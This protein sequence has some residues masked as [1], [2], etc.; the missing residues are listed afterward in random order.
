MEAVNPV[1]TLKAIFPAFERSWDQSLFNAPG[2][3]AAA[4][5]VLAEFSHFYR[6][7]YQSF[8]SS[9]LQQLSGALN[10][11]LGGPDDELDNAVATCFLENVAGEPCVEPLQ[12]LLKSS[13]R[14]FLRSWKH[15]T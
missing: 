12:P 10:N 6:A 15:A 5:G 9:Q 11:W 14:Q 4:H 8:T 13:A 1:Q 3:Q 7:N 2:E